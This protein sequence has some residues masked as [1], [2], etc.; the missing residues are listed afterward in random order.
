MVFVVPEVVE[1]LHS[2]PRGYGE[3]KIQSE[4]VRSA[5]KK[6]EGGGWGGASDLLTAPHISAFHLLDFIEC[7]LCFLVFA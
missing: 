4:E 3:K 1:H 5:E 2:L 7:V 6:T